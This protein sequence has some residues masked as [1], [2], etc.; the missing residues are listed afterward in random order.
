[1]PTEEGGVAS[2]ERGDAM[3][4]STAKEHCPGLKAHA[5]AESTSGPSN[6]CWYYGSCTLTVQVGGAENSFDMNVSFESAIYTSPADL[7]LLDVCFVKIAAAGQGQSGWGMQLKARCA[8]VETDADT[9]KA[10]GL[11]AA[12]GSN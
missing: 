8:D 10:S 12:T 11:P 7:R 9:A 2:L 4:D 5:V 6:T 1:M 3:N